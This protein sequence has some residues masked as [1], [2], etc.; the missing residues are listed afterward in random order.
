MKG[1]RIRTGIQGLDKRMQ[2]GIPE[3]SVVL[4]AGRAGSM[5]SSVAFNMLFQYA[6]ETGKQCIYLTLEQKSD[7]LLFH[8]ENLGIDTSTLKNMM[9]ALWRTIGRRLLWELGD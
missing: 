1:V 9:Y 5:K 8:M 6:K 4:I 3:G 2:G 7:S